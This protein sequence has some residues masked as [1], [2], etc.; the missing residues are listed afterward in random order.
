[1]E[2][3]LPV[4]PGSIIDRSTCTAVRLERT[5]PSTKCFYRCSSGE[6][7]S[8]ELRP[9]HPNG[10]RRQFFCG[11]SFHILELKENCVT[12][13][14]CWKH[15]LYLTWKTDIHLTTVYPL[16]INNSYSSHLLPKVNAAI[17]AN[18]VD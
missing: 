6:G 16:N 11:L 4:K 14:I 1:M 3:H 17:I 9:P 18:G 10:G 15:S 7:T 5:R 8:V 2:G 13:T 12:L